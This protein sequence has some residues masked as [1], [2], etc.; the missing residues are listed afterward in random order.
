MYSPLCAWIACSTHSPEGKNKRLDTPLSRHISF[1]HNYLTLALI[2]II[3]YLH[4]FMQHRLTSNLLCN[5]RWP[6]IYDHIA[7]IPR[8]LGLQ[9]SPHL[10]PRPS[11]M[12]GK[13]P[14]YPDHNY[15]YYFRRQCCTPF[16]WKRPTLK[17]KSQPG[18]EWWE[19][20]LNGELLASDSY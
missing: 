12:L 18:E 3:L 11:P 16:K 5:R 14:T 17:T 2:L 4:W 9:A 6:W 13:S 10:K 8:V 7:S 20:T 19:W 15:F 1:Y